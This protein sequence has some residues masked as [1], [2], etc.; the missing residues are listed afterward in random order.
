VF[1]SV[2]N[3]SVIPSRVFLQCR[4]AN[5]ACLPPSATVLFEGCGLSSGVDEQARIL[6]GMDCASPDLRVSARYED[7]SERSGTSLMDS[8]PLPPAITEYR[9]ESVQSICVPCCIGIFRP[10]CFGS[11]NCHR[12]ISFESNWRLEGIG[13]GLSFVWQSLELICIP[14]A[15][16]IVP[17]RCFA[18]C[19]SLRMIR[20]APTSTLVAVSAE[21]LPD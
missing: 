8:S 12:F 1:Q 14:G 20:L 5:S 10:D 15:V 11:C 4:T 6:I 16:V 13:S 9:L 7:E 3:P 19:H 2:I 18:L 21:E 17:H